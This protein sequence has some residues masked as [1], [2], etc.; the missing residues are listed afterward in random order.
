[1]ATGSERERYAKYLCS[2]EWWAK[3]NAVIARA[4]GKCEKCGNTA[5]HVHHL[6]YIRKYHERLEDLTA[7]CEECHESIHNPKPI[8]SPDDP[9]EVA[10]LV[11]AVEDRRAQM[12]VERFVMHGMFHEADEFRKH[13]NWLKSPDYG[14]TDDEA[15]QTLDEAIRRD[16]RLKELRAISD[17]LKT[18]PAK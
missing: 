12:H 9:E 1:M 18:A 13:H 16:R 8:A 14:N 4:S 2:P 17:S 11:Q 6:T 15:A 5:R 7:L 3:R 10:R